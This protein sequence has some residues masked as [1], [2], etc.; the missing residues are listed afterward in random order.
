MDYRNQARKC[1]HAA[2][3]QINSG[4]DRRLVYAALELRMALEG[5][6]YDR[7]LAYKDEFPPK[8]YETWQPR[9]IMA[10]LLEIDSNADKGGS[11]AIGV[12]PAYGVQP[13]KMNYLGSED[14]LNMSTLRKHYDALGSYLHLPSMKKFLEGKKVDLDRLRSRC[15]EIAHFL[16]QIFRSSV[17]NVTLGS[18][19]TLDCME[20]GKP[21]RKRLPID[22]G[23]TEARCFDCGASYTLIIKS[24][25]KVTWEPHQIE[26]E[27]AKEGCRQVAVLWRHEFEAGRYWTCK[28][29][30]GTNTLSLGLAY[31]GNV[32]K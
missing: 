11:L 20:C 30:G 16:E 17:F 6:T 28:E 26:I 13:E 24:D 8:E 7:A 4:D 9:K 19:A 29:C 12:E 15:E 3:Q 21:V 2:Q 14:V 18:F 10:V 27:C 25:R 31:E 23:K 5:L 22:A 1:L 32:N